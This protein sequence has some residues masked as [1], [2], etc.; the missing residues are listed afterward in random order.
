MQQEIYQAEGYH[1]N[2]E[3]ICD[4]MWA[5]VNYKYSHNKNHVP[6][7]LMVKCVLY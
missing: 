5:N 4:N 6:R 3:L 1:T 2:T 7:G